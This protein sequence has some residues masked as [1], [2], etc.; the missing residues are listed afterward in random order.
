M[1]I[2]KAPHWGSN[3]GYPH[4][5]QT[6]YS[7]KEREQRKCAYFHETKEVTVKKVGNKIVY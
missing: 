3:P 4:R 6:R 1:V 5:W 2:N 7:L